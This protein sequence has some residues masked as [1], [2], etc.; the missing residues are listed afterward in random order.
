MNGNLLPGA[1]FPLNY[2]FISDFIVTKG[3]IVSRDL[4]PFDYVLNRR[5]QRNDG[6][7]RIQRF[8]FNFIRDF[9]VTL[10]SRL[11]RFDQK[12]GFKNR[13]GCHF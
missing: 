13:E 8:P 9:N 2:V 7:H 5:V 1:V 11:F 3:N 4:F 12:L 6:K 10:A